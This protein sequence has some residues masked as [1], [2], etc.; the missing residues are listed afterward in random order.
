VYAPRAG[1]GPVPTLAQLSSSHAEGLAC[2][3][4]AAGVAL[5][6]VA[7]LAGHVVAIRVA[8]TLM[9]VGAAIFVAALARVLAHLRVPRPARAEAHAR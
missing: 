9:T 3:L 4:L 1:R 5:L 2:L 8:G 7:V 6:A